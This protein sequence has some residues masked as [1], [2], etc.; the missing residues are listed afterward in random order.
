VVFDF[1]L[2]STTVVLKHF[3]EG[4][5]IQTYDFVREPHKK[6]LPQVNW[7][8]LFYCTSEACYAK[9]CRGVTEKTLPIERNPFPARTRHYTLTEYIFRL[10]SGPHQLIFKSVTKRLL[11][12]AERL[13][14]SR[15]W[16]LEQ[17][18]KTIV[19]QVTPRL[20]STMS[21]P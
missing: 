9:L 16:L 1:F 10:R 20:P 13:L 17:C 8:V 5:Q 6:N 21:Q 7:H 15:M 11:K 19:Q 4:S 12:S 18:L 3:A 2:T 14:G